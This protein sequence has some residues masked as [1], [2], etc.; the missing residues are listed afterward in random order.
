[1][2]GSTGP[3]GSPR[4]SA[5]RTYRSLLLTRPTTSLKR[6]YYEPEQDDA[7]VIELTGETTLVFSS[8]TDWALQVDLVRGGQLPAWC[9][10]VE[11]WT[12]RALPSPTPAALGTCREVIEQV[13]EVG[14]IV[15]ARLVYGAGLI[16]IASG[17]WF[18]L[19]TEGFPQRPH[20]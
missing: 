16:A 18:T 20:G 3:P 17:D 19:T 8:G 14:E 9:W 15:G 12:V 1:M 13:N 5:C 6:L 10:P 2:R 11:D 4:P 7:L